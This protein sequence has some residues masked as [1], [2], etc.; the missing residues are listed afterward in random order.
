MTIMKLH[1]EIEQFLLAAP[2]VGMS[3]QVARDVKADAFIL[4]LDSQIAITLD[5]KIGEQLGFLRERSWTRN[6]TPLAEKK[7][8]FLNWKETLPFADRLEPVDP[9]IGFILAR[10]IMLMGSGRITPPPIT[11]SVYGHLPFL[12]NSSS[13]AVF[14]RYE[15]FPV[16]RRVDQITNTIAAGT[17]AAPALEMQFV[18]SGLA[19]VGRF[20][21]PSLFPARWRWEIQPVV[22]TQLRCGASVPLYGQSGGGVEVMFPRT[23]S[24]RGPIADPVVLPIF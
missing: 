22:G 3:I 24:N 14:Y 8:D 17:Y 20:A 10:L 19:A 6:D 18:P 2:E 1:F 15:P 9:D 23:F 16:S 4:I 7:A 5:E 12:D 11:P 21:L 13:E